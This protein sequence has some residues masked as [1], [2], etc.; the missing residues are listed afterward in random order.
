MKRKTL[1]ILAA[2]AA[3]AT[4][5]GC[6]S[7][8]NEP[9]ENT[10]S[11]PDGTEAGGVTNAGSGEE[12]I[13]RADIEYNPEDYVTLGEYMGLAVTLNEADYQVTEE[14]VNSYADQMILYS[15]PYVADEAKTV[16][17]KDDVVDVSYVGKKDGEPFEGGSAENQIVDVAKNASATA[18][19]GYIEGFT[20]GLVG[21]KVGESVD[22]EMT[23]PEDYDS[24]E[25]KGQKVVF[26]FTVNSIGSLVTRETLT[27][28]FVK[29]KL[30]LDSVEAF[31]ADLRSYLE[32][33]AKAKKESDLR[34]A[35]IQKVTETCPVSSLP[36]GLLDARTDEYVALF[37]KQYCPEGTDFSEFLQKNYNVSKDEF[38]AQNRSN[39]ETSI[40]QE[41]IFEAIAKKENLQFDETEY[42]QYISNIVSGGGFASKDAL[43]ENYGFDKE[44]G[45]QYFENVYMVNKACSLVVEN[46]D[47]T[48]ESSSETGQAGAQ[49]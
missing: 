10:E 23:F 45:K 32:E 25:L 22:C 36:E 19:T 42:D 6:G 18:G 13:K 48:Y 21:A 43:Y 20:D 28:E 24:E 3:L 49:E 38:Y 29:E 39:M 1:I 47:V 9:E 41:L 44:D 33:S 30:E 2:C 26:T 8:P 27:D 4:A 7:R 37:Q 14:D 34:T 46:A 40:T 15:D 16:V 12:A 35:V 17:E 5:A 31:Y 11:L